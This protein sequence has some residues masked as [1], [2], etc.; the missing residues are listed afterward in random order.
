MP[1]KSGMMCFMCKCDNICILTLY[2][3]LKN[4]YK[5]VTLNKNAPLRLYTVQQTEYGTLFAEN[6]LL[7]NISCFLK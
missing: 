5:T 3:Q 4:N 7:I 6:I 1:K 2:D